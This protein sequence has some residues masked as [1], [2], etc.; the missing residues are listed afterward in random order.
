MIDDPQLEETIRLPVSGRQ[1]K[2]RRLP[3]SEAQAI[4]EKLGMKDASAI[5]DALK[6]GLPEPFGVLEVMR[7]V[8][9]EVLGKA[10]GPG[11]PESERVAWEFED[12]VFV[13][14]WA[15]RMAESG[16]IGVA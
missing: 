2:A 4:R 5:R 1:M 9:Q 3:P 15:L 16:I 12:V 13:F 10:A 8:V 6:K 14:L 11:V 7:Q